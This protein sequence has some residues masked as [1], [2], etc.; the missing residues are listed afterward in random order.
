MSARAVVP[1]TRSDDVRLVDPHD[2]QKNP[3]NPRL[4]FREDELL[5]LEQSI[6]EQ[7]IL[8]PLTVFQPKRGRLTLLD[9]ERRWRA[10]IRLGMSRVPV[11][12][13][14][15][16][17]PLQ[18]IMMMFAIHKARQDWDPLPTAYKLQ[19][20]ETL[21]LQQYGKRPTIA[22]LAQLSS[23]P[24]GAVS[25][26]RMLLGL[27]KDLRDDLMHELEKPKEEQ[28]LR[29]AQVIE[30]T[31]SATSLV[32]RDVLDSE[33]G[34]QLRNSLISKF[35][36][37]VITD[38]VAPRKLARIAL[39][40]AREGIPRATAAR[41]ARRLIDDPTYTIDDAVAETIQKVDFERGIDE[42]ASRL[43]DQLVEYRRHRYEVGDQLRKTLSALKRTLHQFVP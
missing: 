22:Q 14:P 35:R 37:G 17:N 36:K 5:Q 24:T 6:K 38:T 32:K 15:E 8:V 19:D 11:I 39:A 1:R 27:P 40:V 12:I 9:G 26:L 2:I 43:Q 29:V 42:L 20:L 13:Q 28:R 41:A 3:E 25:Q 18:N 30:A 16:P 21:Y 34:D 33:T 23:L 7:G 31:K 10:A 4:V